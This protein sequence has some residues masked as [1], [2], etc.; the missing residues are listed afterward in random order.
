[1]RITSEREN[2]AKKKR[3]KERMRVPLRKC[4]AP[5]R[6]S[7]MVAGR[8]LIHGNELFQQTTH[9]GCNKQWE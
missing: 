1:M 7:T 4:I 2:E 8:G 3:E 6:I 9:P 5:R